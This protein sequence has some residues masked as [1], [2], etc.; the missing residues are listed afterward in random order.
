[1]DQ[2]AAADLPGAGTTAPPGGDPTWARLEDQL[3]WY[4][5]RSADNQRRY[6]LLKIG[7]LVAAATVPV[8]AGLQVTPWVTGGLGSAIVVME[9]LQQLYQFHERWLSYRSIHAALL[10][11]KHLYLARA[12]DYAAAPRPEALLAERVEA[13]LS[14]EVTAWVAEQRTSPVRRA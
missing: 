4:D 2:V 14:Q 9:G 13:L 7:Q 12:G 6:R 8:V 5:R 10:R 11:E 1:M 3:G